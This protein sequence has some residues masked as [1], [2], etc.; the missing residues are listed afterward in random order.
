MGVGFK[1][2]FVEGEELSGATMSA[3]VGKVPGQVG[4][5]LRCLETTTRSR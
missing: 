5:Y 2:R 4:K 1:L 3:R